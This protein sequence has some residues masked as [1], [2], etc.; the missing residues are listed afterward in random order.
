MKTLVLCVALGL[1]AQ[2]APCGSQPSL[3]AAPEITAIRVQLFQDKTGSWSED[4]LQSRDRGA[5]NSVAGEHS[6]NAALVIVEISAPRDGRYFRPP[7]KYRVQLVASEP[8]RAAPLLDRSQAVPM[9]NDAG[10]AYVPFLFYQGGC[11]AVRIDVTLVGPRRT[12]PVQE[13]LALACGE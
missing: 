5:W 6:A 8:R 12:R 3:V 11:V 9:L 4:I 1:A 7:A 13:I 10:K 2:A